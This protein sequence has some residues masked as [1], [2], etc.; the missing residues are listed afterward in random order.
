MNM[1]ILKNF[2]FAISIFMIACFSAAAP[3][4]RSFAYELCNKINMWACETGRTINGKEIKKN[5]FAD[6][7]FKICGG[8]FECIGVVVCIENLRIAFILNEIDDCY[9][10]VVLLQGEE[11][12]SSKIFPKD[13]VQVAEAIICV[14]MKGFICSKGGSEFIDQALIEKEYV[15]QELNCK[16]SSFVS[17]RLAYSW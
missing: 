12:F 1:K 17:D 3:L 10:L 8:K 2:K 4:N 16:V 15:L 11:S 14:V 7:G 13:V 5:D 6:L 9:H